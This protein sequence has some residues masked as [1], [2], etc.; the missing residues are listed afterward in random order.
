MLFMKHIGKDYYLQYVTYEFTYNNKK[1]TGHFKA[2]NLLG[3]QKKGSY[4]RIK[5]STSNPKRSLMKGVYR[6][7]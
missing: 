4:V 7:N 5:F 6:N 2:G 1:Y 3:K